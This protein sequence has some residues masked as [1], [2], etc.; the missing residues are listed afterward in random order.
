[1]LK[2]LAERN[3]IKKKHHMQK[4]QVVGQEAKDDT[5][6][7]RNTESGEISRKIKPLSDLVNKKVL[8]CLAKWT[9]QHA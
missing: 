2:A 1:M 4:I 3:E 6:E 9:K 7:W 8:A 5:K